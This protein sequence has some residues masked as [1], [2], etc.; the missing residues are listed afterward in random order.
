M[1]RR[2]RA[3]SHRPIAT[4]AERKKGNATTMK[5]RAQTHQSETAEQP[6]GNALPHPAASLSDAERAFLDMLNSN[7]DCL[8]QICLH[9]SDRQPEH[10]RDLYQEIVCALWESW[11]SFRNESAAGTWMYRV[12]L[13]VAISDVRRRARQPLFVPLETWIYNTLADEI[14]KAPPDYYRLLD[15]LDPEE[16][17][18]LDLRLKKMPLRSIAQALGTTEPAIKQRLYRL[19][20]K[21]NK[22]KQH[23][24]DNE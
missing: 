3:T 18:L 17:A 1:N 13:N 21:I 7:Q 11:P 9:F 22:L 19:R 15:A 14:E 24:Y 4:T 8:F 5:K 6:L 20:Q 16:R 23:E 10:V 2:A 12:A